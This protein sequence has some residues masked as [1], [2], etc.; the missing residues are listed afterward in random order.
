LSRYYIGLS[1]SGHDPSFCIVDESAQVLFAEATERYIQDKRAWGCLP[2]HKGHIESV[3]NDIISKDS[4]ARF[5]LATS[6]KSIKADLPVEV[7]STLLPAHVV[8]WIKSL[9]ALVQGNSGIHCQMIAEERIL[10]TIANFDHHLCHATAALYSV[11]V[12]NAICLVLDGEGEVGASSL[13]KWDEGKLKRVWRSWGLGSLGTFYS[14]LTQLCGFSAVEGEEWKVMGLA[15][16]GKV[17]DRLVG[18]LKQLIFIEN[19][20]P[21]LGVDNNLIAV[22][23][24]LKSF[25]RKKSDPITDAAN[26]AASGQF[27]YSQLANEIISEFDKEYKN[28]ILTGGCAL[29][30]SY[31][32]TI[33]N[34]HS[35][36][37]VHI[38]SAPADDGNSLGAAIQ[39]WKEDHP[40][41]P[42]P[43]N[44]KTP[45]LGT[46]VTTKDLENL[47]SNSGLTTTKIDDNDTDFIAKKLAEGYV[48]GV[49]RGKAEFGPRALGNRSILAD[50]RQKEMKEKINKIVKGREA[51]RPFAPVVPLKDMHKWFENPQACLYMSY[52][53]KWKEE[54]RDLVPSVVHNDGT[55]RVQSVEQE[56]YPWLFNLT[57][58]FEK[59]TGIPVL[60]NTSFNVMGKPIVHSVN[61]AISVLHTTALDAVLIENIFVEK[62]PE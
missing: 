54:I 7:S 4:D 31:N 1:T 16:Y 56:T 33:L 42:L 40:Q 39:A 5:K 29:N 55:G 61:D 50:P 27:V 21:M 17:D 26:M 14:V 58:S 20:K 15:A 46:K 49:M 48:I 38:P 18:L 51:Y 8:E 10:P 34:N 24:E 19:G 43:F 23:D 3:I 57:Q 37:S 25:A 30:S 60:L 35:F 47:V 12:N 53:L 2:D 22:M 28:L 52:T 41:E 9:Q 13:F 45:F 6:W 44:N 32:G 36:E 62:L 59:I 11:P